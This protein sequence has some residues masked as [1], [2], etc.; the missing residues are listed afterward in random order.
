MVPSIQERFVADEAD[1]I[2]PEPLRR[3]QHQRHV[4]V[5]DQPVRMQ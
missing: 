3:G 1:L 2:D 5:A 4:F